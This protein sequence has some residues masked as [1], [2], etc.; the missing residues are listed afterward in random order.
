[1]KERIDMT[2]T[3]A[4][5]SAARLPAVDAP[6]RSALYAGRALSG[7]ATVFLAW[8]AGMKLVLH[9]MV[10]EASA[11]MGMTTSFVQTVGAILAAC[12]AVSLIPRTAVLGAVL[13]TG[14]LGGA[15]AVHLQAGDPLF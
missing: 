9:P 2:A 11:K 6:K 10:V 5:L 12:L 1:M 4:S 15:V 14:Y 8:D 13:V 7:L 3:T